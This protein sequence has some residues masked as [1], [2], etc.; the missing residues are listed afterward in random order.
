MIIHQGGEIDAPLLHEVPQCGRLREDA[1][2]TTYR[3][4]SRGLLEAGQ[5]GNHVSESLELSRLL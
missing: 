5:G 1:V 3:E 2:S 4:E